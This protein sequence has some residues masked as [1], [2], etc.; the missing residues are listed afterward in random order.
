MKILKYIKTLP[1]I[2]AVLTIVV[3]CEKLLETEPRT[4]I[5]DEFAMEDFAGIDATIIG[6]YSRMASTTYYGRNFTIAGELMADQA[7]VSLTG[8][9]FRNHPTNREGSGFYLWNHNYNNINR[10]NLI[11]NY[12]DYVD[13]KESQINQLKGET[14]FMRALF[15]FDLLRVYARSPL[16]QEPLVKGRPLGV[17]IRTKAFS[18]VDHTTFASRSGIDECYDQVESDLLESIDYF[19]D[20]LKDFPYRANKLAAKALLARVWLYRGKWAEARD[21][22]LEVIDDAP[23][24][25]GPSQ[26]KQV[27]AGIPGTESIF[28][29]YYAEGNRQHTNNSIAGVALRTAE[30]NAG[31]GEV[32]FRQ[33]LLDQYE[34]GDVRAKMTV[35]FNKDGEDV[36]YQTKFA[37]HKGQHYWDDV[38]V[39]RT[40]E[41]YLILAEAYWENE[42]YEEAREVLNFLRENRGLDHLVYSDVADDELID[43]ILKE[44]RVELCWENSHRWFDL[45]R[46]GM[47]IPKGVPDIDVGEPLLY[48]D[49]RVVDRI[50]RSGEAEVNPNFVQNPGY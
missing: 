35:E 21:M 43:A 44:R 28:E 1:V 4:S 18:G 37:G 19:D 23:G 48:E 40:S 3:S 30:D 46:R 45:R 41:M 36:V 6:L 31:Y 47:D 17:I 42:Q 49:Y 24:L 16:Y 11:L 29:L 8:S 13:A 9:R 7:K 15:H 32:I 12:I 34:P 2:I 10:T 50:S 33:D 25:S 27:F 26:Y 5:S 14:Y 38:P 20:N 22:A 39:I